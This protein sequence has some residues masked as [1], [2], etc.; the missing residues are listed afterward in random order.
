M[1]LLYNAEK[2]NRHTCLLGVMN[3]ILV[4]FYLPNMWFS[5]G[6][7]ECYH[8]N[9]VFLGNQHEMFFLWEFTDRITGCVRKSDNE[10]KKIY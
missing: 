10:K 7:C 2:Q 1:L 4:I 6:S 3:N 5:D 8:G 9:D